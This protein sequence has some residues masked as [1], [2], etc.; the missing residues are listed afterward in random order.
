MCS[1]HTSTYVQYDDTQQ[2]SEQVFII[3]AGITLTGT[4]ISNSSEISIGEVV[5]FHSYLK[6]NQNRWIQKKMQTFSIFVSLSLSV[7]SYRSQF[8]FSFIHFLVS[9]FVH[10][11]FI[12]SCHLRNRK[13]IGISF[14]LHFFLSFNNFTSIELKKKNQHASFK[15]IIYLFRF[16]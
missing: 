5:Y 1:S 9:F 14:F 2:V 15:I 16:S 13:D 11:E 4:H 10:T 6:H 12:M 7:S 3:V 8:V